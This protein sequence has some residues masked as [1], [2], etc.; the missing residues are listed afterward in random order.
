MLESYFSVDHLKMVKVLMNLIFL[1]AFLCSSAFV[2]QGPYKN[3]LSY[4]V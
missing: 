2:M 4:A 1:I 3:L